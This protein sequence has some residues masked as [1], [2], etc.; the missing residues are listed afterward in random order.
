MARSYRPWLI[1]FFLVVIYAVPFTQAAV[2]IARG[3]RPR[4]LDLFMTA[5]KAA[6]LRA[7]EQDLQRASIFEVAARPWM[8][9]IWYATLRNP[10]E[11]A[12]VGLDGWF[13]YKPDL[14]YLVEPYD[15]DG[16]FAAI[17]SFHKQ[18]AS[19]GTHLIVIPVP[20]KPSVYPD[21][22]SRRADGGMMF[23]HTGRLIEQLRAAGVETSDVLSTLEHWRTS[24]G[25]AAPPYYLVR[26]THWTGDT[27]RKA[28]EAVAANVRARGWFA[29]GSTEYKT[30]SLW[31]HRRGDVIRMIDVPRLEETFPPEQVRCEQVL[32]K[33]GTPYKDD[34]AS[35][36]LV[37][38]D[39]FLR[40]YE[41]DEPKSAGFIAHLARELRTPVA[42][43]VNDGGAST[44]VRQQLARRP[45]LLAGKKVVIWEFV[46]RDIRF[47][48]DGWQ[49][50][51]LPSR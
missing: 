32:S 40:I 8:Q 37:L 4:F 5:P 26:D 27:A 12:V 29:G 19:R 22:V 33:D 25:A 16:A 15:G 46:E 24:D 42:S 20:G 43:I 7:F 11:K 23:S 51:T 45:A 10:G 50:V 38:G 1:G 35:P 18:L 49:E 28:A 2:E 3:D 30:K 13:F 6:N 31:I 47:G 36:V 21:R 17:L 41:T 14:R 39:S 9:Y 44:L 34:P 48:T